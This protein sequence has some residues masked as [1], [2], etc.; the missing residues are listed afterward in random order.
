MVC[1]L[2][3]LFACCCFY[4]CLRDERANANISKEGRFFNALGADVL[5]QRIAAKLEQKNDS[6]GFMTPFV[7]RY[8]YPLWADAC[9]FREN[10]HTVF[11]VP[12]RS[13]VPYAEINA[14][15]FF[16][17]FSDHTRYRIYTRAMAERLW[18]R[19]GGDGV[20]ETWMFDYFTHRILHRRPRSNLRFEEVCESPSVRSSGGGVE[21]HCVH[22]YAGYEGAEGDLG[23]HC[24][25]TPV[26]EEDEVD[27]SSEGDEGSGGDG[28]MWDDGDGSYGDLDTGD[29]GDG[30]SASSNPQP[31]DPEPDPPT[32]PTSPCGKAQKLSN[33]SSLKSKV[34]D[35]FNAVQNYR[36]GDLEDGWIKTA[37]GAYIA[38]A[39]RTEGSLGYSASS[40]AGQKITEEYHTHPAGSCIPSFADLR[41]LARRCINEQIDMENFSYGVISCM[42]CFTL[43]V[44]SEEAFREFAESVLDI[45]G[46]I[47][48]SYEKMLKIDNKKGVNTAIAKFIDFL[49]D[50]KSGLDVLFNESSYDS[51]GNAILNGWQAKDS[52]GTAGLSN[53]DCN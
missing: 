25:T 5:L 15:W 13:I 20:E 3:T 49:K 32:D 11:A 30:G 53:Y 26:E 1:V 33:D 28:D 51:S 4:A 31:D 27:T 52:N 46:V 38:P 23:V 35:L 41:V 29:C 43:V 17:V 50:S 8:G 10:G 45:T 24:W 21:W 48:N 22:A 12:V 2:M 40:L 19:V 34:N 47:E 42:G 39:R 44:T 16:T 9:K 18:Q 6:S 37:T 14:I 7:A 36:A